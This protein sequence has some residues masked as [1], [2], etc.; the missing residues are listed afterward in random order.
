MSDPVFCQFKHIP[1]KRAGEQ[2]ASNIEIFVRPKKFDKKGISNCGE[3]GNG[4]INFTLTRDEANK[5][6][7]QLAQV[8]PNENSTVWFNILSNPLD[9]LRPRSLVATTTDVHQQETTFSASCQFGSLR[10][11]NQFYSHVS[12]NGQIVQL[13]FILL[14]S[15]P[16]TLHIEFD[17][18]RI[19]IP[20][21][22]IQKKNI[23]VNKDNTENGIYVLL[24]LKYSPNVYRMEPIKDEDKTTKNSNRTPVRLCSDERNGDFI[25]DIP[26]CSDL[27]LYF[28][29]PK[30]RAWVFLS[31]FLTDRP[32]R[33]H[34]NFSTF[35]ISDWSKEFNKN[36]RPD[37]FS[38]RNA[39][40]QDRYALQMLISLGF[41]FRDKW[42]QL[43]DQELNWNRWNV[44]DRYTLC[45]YTLEQLKNDHGY[46]LS[47]TAKDYNETR[48][49]ATE[50]DGNMNGQVMLVENKQRLQ[51]AV[52]TL[53]PLKISFQP[54]EVT[55]GNRALRNPE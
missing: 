7:D 23:L 48:K 34:I 20:F 1:S 3:D 19:V 12:F 32:E 33:Y 45:C 49:T 41:V 46:D 37:P 26:Q 54:L 35:K 47:R 29:P 52:C 44:D 9:S 15:I 28:V 51:V 4:T 39:S 6:R 38:Y 36:Q 42:A 25:K 55:T 18:K 11:Y 5:V 10:S 53:T 21:V 17:D 27:V 2:L 24:P 8:L 13:S 50:A 40:F 30:E 16:H 22:S 14:K 31:Y 43:T